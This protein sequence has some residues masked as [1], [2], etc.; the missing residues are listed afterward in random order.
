MFQLFVFYVAGQ[1][2][3]VCESQYAER[4]ESYLVSRGLEY[5]V[6]SVIAPDED[7]CWNALSWFA[8]YEESSH[9]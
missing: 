9:V 3:S 2:D 6:E 8:L 4:A 1:F 7:S 5:R